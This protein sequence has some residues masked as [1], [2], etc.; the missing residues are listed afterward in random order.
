MLASAGTPSLDGSGIWLA[1]EEDRENA[2]RSPAIRR[3][4]RH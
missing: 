4:S 1:A 2:L 3:Q